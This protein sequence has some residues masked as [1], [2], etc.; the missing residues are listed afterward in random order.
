MPPLDLVTSLLLTGV[1]AAILERRTQRFGATVLVAAGLGVAAWWV[2]IVCVHDRS[3]HSTGLGQAL[4]ILCV[5]VVPATLG[6][7]IGYR[8]LPKNVPGA[9]T[10]NPSLEWRVGP[11]LAAPVA[12]LLLALPGYYAP[13]VS[14]FAPLATVQPMVVAFAVVPILIY[15]DGYDRSRRR[16]T[17]VLP[18]LFLI[19]AIA[20]GAIEVWL[21]RQESAPSR[22]IHRVIHFGWW[23]LAAPSLVMAVDAW[24][25]PTPAA[26][27][28]V[29]SAS[30]RPD[31]E[32]T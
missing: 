18:A 17:R 3:P 8:I 5:Y 11:S 12:A 29:G 1:L 10:R 21:M 2:Y 22:N 27:G 9:L 24:H 25:E 30:G 26:S 14:S 32:A 4:V 15:F 28:W 16:L 31:P 20:Y 7:V 19:A 13:S 6:A 23:M